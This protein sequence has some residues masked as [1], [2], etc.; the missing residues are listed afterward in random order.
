MG[1]G[2]GEQGGQ[3]PLD[4]KIISK[5]IVFSISRGKNQISPLLV[6]LEKILGK[7]P[8]GPPGKNPSDA[9]DPCFGS[10]S[11][12]NFHHKNIQARSQV[13]RFGGHNKF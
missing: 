11:W 12:C 7:S 9:R 2:R 3:A 13:L 6:P 5:N 1:V 4:F 10:I 8:T